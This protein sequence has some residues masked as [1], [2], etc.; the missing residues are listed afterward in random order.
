MDK[1][2]TENNLERFGLL[3]LS[4]LGA[5]NLQGWVDIPLP[6]EFILPLV[7]D[8]IRAVVTISVG[9]VHKSSIEPSNTLRN[10]PLDVVHDG[11][12]HGVGGDV[13]VVAR[14]PEG[15]HVLPQGSFLNITENTLIYI[16]FFNENYLFT[17]QFSVADVPWL[18]QLMK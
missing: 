6:F 2:E 8:L 17:W 1:S 13:L 18:L 7:R 10:D 5:N 14:L 11:V 4:G 16:S 9:I 3:H 12:G 15:H